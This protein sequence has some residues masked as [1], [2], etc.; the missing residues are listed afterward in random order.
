MMIYVIQHHFGKVRFS[1]LGWK[2][3]KFTGVLRKKITGEE[4]ILR[5]TVEEIEDAAG[6]TF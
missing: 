5:E 4:K 1:R 3:P 6:A 2:Q